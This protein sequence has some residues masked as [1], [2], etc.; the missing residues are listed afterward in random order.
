MSE[1]VNKL[2]RELKKVPRRKYKLVAKKLNNG[3]VRGEI[4]TKLILELF[5][6]KVRIVG[7]LDVMSQVDSITVYEQVI[8]DGYAYGYKEVILSPNDYK[9]LLDLFEQV[10][11]KDIVNNT[12][13]YLS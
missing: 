5:E 11:F 4:V 2:L 1:S 6:G 12:T 8:S 7:Y 3:P 10:S 13:I 9:I